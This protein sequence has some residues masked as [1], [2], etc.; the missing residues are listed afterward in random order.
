V[1]RF[2]LRERGDGAS[3]TLTVCEHVVWQFGCSIGDE[4][5]LPMRARCLV[6]R[7]SHNTSGSRSLARLEPVSDP[8]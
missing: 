2:L 7:F 1:G 6:E 4:S 5:A 3:L 8:L